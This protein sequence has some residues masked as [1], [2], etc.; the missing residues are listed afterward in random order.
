VAV[1]SEELPDWLKEL[2]P[3]G[4]GVPAPPALTETP[5]LAPTVGGLVAAQLPAWLKELQPSGAP[6]ELEKQEPAEAEGILEGVRGALPV[7]DIV[8]Q[9]LEAGTPRPLYPQIPANDLAQ[10]GAL[11]ALLARG[12]A[13]VVQREDKGRARTLWSNTQR[14]IVFL[15]IAILAILPLVQPDLVYGL[16]S[17]PPPEAANE[18][19]F[20]NIQAL[21]SGAAVLVAFD[22]DATQSPEMDVQARVLL[23]HLAARQANI[24]VASL[25]QT[26]PAV[27]QAVV[28]QVNSTLTGTLP[29]KVEYRGYLPGQDTAVAVFIQSTPISMVV[30]LAA[31]PD[32]V[33]WWA[34]Q[35]AGRPDAPTFLAGVSASAEPM[36]RPYVESHQ[37]SGMIAGVPGATA[38][39]LK[40]RQVIQ[41]DK[42][43]EPQVLAPLASIG[44]VNAAL[45][46]LIVLGGMIQLVSGRAPQPATRSGGGQRG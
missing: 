9:A 21:P 36:S 23:R 45:A 31:T 10:A 26:G 16:V 30:D 22:Y 42:E 29:I 37:V 4:T 34:E 6:V 43:G 20:N 19:M 15:V 5:T 41:D 40:L 14:W 44:L 8:S 25:Y 13:A 24:K 17:S 28:N 32:S 39:R 1:P 18:G 35:L 46:A 11:H 27:A 3:A 12:T 2:K 7:A 33:R 38:Y